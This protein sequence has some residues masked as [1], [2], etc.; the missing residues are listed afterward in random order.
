MYPIE[1]QKLHNGVGLR[2]SVPEQQM[3]RHGGIPA[4]KQRIRHDAATRLSAAGVPLRPEAL[5]FRNCT[6]ADSDR[7]G[8]AVYQVQLAE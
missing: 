4:L 7:N 6:D 1:Y 3:R 8:I 5:T 2:A